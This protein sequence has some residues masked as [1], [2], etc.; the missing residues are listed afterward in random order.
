[1]YWCRMS[2]LMRDRSHATCSESASISWQLC[3]TRPVA[4]SKTKK[5]KSSLF[6][7]GYSSKNLLNAT[8][9]ASH[10]LVLT[11]ATGYA[12]SATLTMVTNDGQGGVDTD[13]VSVT[14]VADTTAPTAT[15]TS[16]AYLAS[17]DTLILT[18]TNFSTLLEA[19]ENASTDI[20]ARLDWTKLLWDINGD[21]DTTANV[22]F[23]EGDITS[24]KVS[25]GTILTIV[26]TGTKA[27]DLEATSG[28]A[29]AAL[30][31]LDITAGFTRDAAGNAASTDTRA[32]APLFTHAG[33]S[34]IDLGNYGQLIAPVQ[35]Q[36][37][38][39][40]FWDRSGDGTASDADWTS[41]DVLDGLFNHDVAGVSNTTDANADSAFGTTDTYRYA[42]LNGVKL[43]LPTLNGEAGVSAETAAG[44]GYT[45]P[46]S[47]TE[48]TDAGSAT[49]GTTGPYADFT[50][51]W[52]AYNGTSTEKNIPGVPPAW[53][54]TGGPWTA[55]P[56]GNGHLVGA[57]H[58]GG[59][60]GGAVDTFSSYY[61]ALQVL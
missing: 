21:N 16:G 41:H 17:T 2:P 37:K 14:V 8:L 40:Y 56:G 50:A 54:T 46:W 61:V 23:V 15:H 45:S 34:T 4:G 33:Q 51:I 48:Y 31:T 55:T 47:G 7:I 57:L 59:V 39:Y 22:S 11:A 1:M 6:S 9:A 26:L 28:Y 24:A 20:K 5:S 38:W 43:A 53:P 10:G 44:T 42:T 52:D 27:S 32:N 18:G 58:S 49:N 29:V 60:W 13:V 19:G 3:N 25:N 36:G 30:D 12:G 35:V